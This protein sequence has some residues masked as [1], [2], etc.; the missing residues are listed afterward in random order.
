MDTAFWINVSCGGLL[1]AAWI[2]AIYK[3]ISESGM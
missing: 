3:A 1:M 2:Y